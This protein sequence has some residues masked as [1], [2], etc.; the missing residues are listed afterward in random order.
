MA[1]GQTAGG[2]SGIGTIPI[3][4][5]LVLIDFLAV[6]FYIRKQYPQG[7]ARVISYAALILITFYLVRIAI[8][9]LLMV[10]LIAF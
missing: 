10:F 2:V 6:F 1:L 7:I 4:L 9:I 3:A 5:I 8:A